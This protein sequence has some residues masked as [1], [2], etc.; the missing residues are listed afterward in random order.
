MLGRQFLILLALGAGNLPLRADD[1]IRR[2][3]TRTSGHLALN[4]Q[5]RFVFRSST[6]NEP[7]GQIEIVRFMPKVVG[8][9]TMPLCHQIRFGNGELVLGI[10]ERLDVTH[11]HV[12]AA[13]AESLAIPRSA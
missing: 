5:G 4:E 8:S 10:I 12:R 1:A 3:G 2:D 9:T 11:L 7:I 6:G 13:W